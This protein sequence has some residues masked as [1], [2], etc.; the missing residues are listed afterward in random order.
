MDYDA[1]FQ[2]ALKYF[3]QGALNPSEQLARQLI[4]VVPDQPDVLNLLGLI[5]QTRGIHKEACSYFSAAIRIRPKNAFYYFN[6]G[7]SLKADNHLADA[8]QSF[9]KVLQLAPSIQEAY[10]E[11]ALIYETLGQLSEARK[12]WQKALNLNN[13]DATAAINLANSYRLDFPDKAE[14]EL[15]E[16]SKRWPNN[17]ALWYDLS[18]L[19]YKREDAATA[20]A[21]AKKTSA[22]IPDADAVHY[23]L[24]LISL[25]LQQ[26]STAEKCFD[27]AVKLNDKNEAALL[28]L[29]DIKSQKK[30]FYQAEQLYQKILEI[31]PKNFEACNNYAEML[32][33]QKRL[34][35]SLEIYR[36]AVILSPQSAE[37]S[38]N[39][40]VILKDQHEYS[41][42]TGLFFNALQLNPCLH[43]ASINLAETLVLLSDVN[44][45]LAVKLAEKW[46]SSFPEDPFARHV[47]AALRGENIEN[48]QI[49]IENLFD[50]FADTYELVMQNLDYSAPLAIRR[51]AGPME[52]RIADLGCGTGLVGMAV[53]TDRNQIIGV[54]L[55]AKMLALAK[56]KNVYC[57]LLKDD[58]LNFLRHRSDFEWIL[59]ADV[60]GYMGSLDNF[61]ALCRNKKLIFSIETLQTGQTFQIQKNGRFKHNPEKIKQQ[62]TQNGFTKINMQHLILRNENNL[63]VQ[64]CIFKAE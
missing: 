7:F 12:Y 22:L 34:P 20:L 44:E 3:D 28:C 25:A 58:V 55:S 45:N 51:I 63:P 42:A 53:K 16:L 11:I 50:N 56:E 6:L 15:L 18:W 27:K 8:L 54:D 33:R 57:E 9:N 64:G 30:L 38:N 5:A 62:L 13:N 37:T 41:E 32:Y 40:G 17:P 24:G 49:F 61:F 35:E 46:K 29:A 59:A 48:N 60:L 21:F 43:E 39:I 52:G 1:I 4:K 26:K 31:N 23:L 36:K 19:A 14:K 2:Q 10:N 47:S